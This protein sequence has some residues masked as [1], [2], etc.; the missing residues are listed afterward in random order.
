M[1]R[2]TSIDIL[3][4]IGIVLVLV[5]HALGGVV[6]HVAYTFHMPLFFIVCGLFFSDSRGPKE[7]LRRDFKR[8]IIPALFTTAVIV[9][10]VLLEGPVAVQL[11]KVREMLWTDNPSKPLGNV[12]T[13]GNLWFLFAMFFARYFFALAKTY[14]PEKGLGVSCFAI[15]LMAYLLSMC[16]T[17]P[18]SLL[19]GISVLPFIWLGYYIKHHGGA[20]VGIPRLAWLLIPLWVAYIFLGRMHVSDM[21]YSWG[22]VP[23]IFVAAGGT[24]AWYLLSCLIAKHTRYVSGVLA[25]LGTYSLILICVP[26]IETYCF[27]MGEVIPLGLP[28]RPLLVIGGKVAWCAVG[29]WACIKV[30][31]LRKVFGVF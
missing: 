16:F 17:L 6:S 29:L 8:L 26:G 13:P 28:L 3:K 20:P 10:V 23:E 9:A 1:V 14:L 30:P 4:G 2:D 12:L 27:P 24:Y 25:F 19:Q 15:G 7:M 5:A 21:H 11:Q 22:Y 31:L 18:L